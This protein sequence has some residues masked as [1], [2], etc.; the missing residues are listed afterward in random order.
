MDIVG[1]GSTIG[2][3][4]RFTASQP[5]P[6]RFDADVV[7]ETVFFV[8]REN[9]PTELIEGVYGYGHTFPESYTSW[10]HETR[11]S[12]SHQRIIQYDF[13]GLRFLVRT[14]TDA[15]VKDSIRPAIK[16]PKDQT[17][18]ED[19]ITQMAVASRTPST[20]QKM[21]IKTQGQMIP[22]GKIFD[23]K[24]R[25]EQNTFKME[26]ILPRLWVN[27]TSKFLL[28]LHQKG[29][30]NHPGVTDVGHLVT[31]W[32]KDNSSPPGRLH[33]VVN[34]IVDVLRD[35]EAHQ[36]EVS[37]DGQGDLL[38]TKQLGEGRR[39]LPLDLRRRLEDTSHVDP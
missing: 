8:R 13:G 5:K 7:G 18:L 17:S 21:C 30:F 2:N 28:A 36:V 38:I 4:L 6:F 11:G 32:Q 9:S 22:Q 19:A 16:A 3:L 23:I 35:S 39:A 31:K 15:Y 14:E 33:A 1:C 26:E 10:D 34:H 37:W 25:A 20:G 12:V 24:T 29:L 27:Q